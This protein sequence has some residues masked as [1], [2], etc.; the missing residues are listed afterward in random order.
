MTFTGIMLQHKDT[1]NLRQIAVDGNG[2]LVL[3]AP[4]KR[5]LRHWQSSNWRVYERL[6][7]EDPA[8]GS[9]APAGAGGMT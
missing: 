8:G 7:L 5:L 1:K 9:T 3:Y 2:C 6:D 4:F